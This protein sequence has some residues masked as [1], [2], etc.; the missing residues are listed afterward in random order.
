MSNAADQI[1]IGKDIGKNGRYSRREKVCGLKNM[2]GFVT[3]Q[4]CVES[5][6]NNYLNKLV[7]G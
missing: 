2:E 5:F 1:S 6:I 3:M 7:N 4:T